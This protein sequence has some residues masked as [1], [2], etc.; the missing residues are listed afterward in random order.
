MRSVPLVRVERSGTVAVLTI[1]HPPVNTL[2]RPVRRAL[3][4]A[5]DSA[6]LDPGISAV[7]VAG[8]RDFSA[9]ADLAEL[10]SG[11]ALS[12]P[13]LH[14]D[15]AGL[16]DRMRVPSVAALSGVVLGGGLELALACSAR[17][18]APTA[19]FGLPET[20]IGLMPGG[21]GTQRLPRAIGIERGLN[22]IVSGRVIDAATAAAWGLV[23]DIVED[24]EQAALEHALRLA[25]SGERPRLRDVQ[26]T[27][28]LAAAFADIALR[29][30]R[31]AR[32][33]PGVLFAIEA[34]G[35][36]A[37]LP[38]DE[39]IALESSL[40][41]RLASTPEAKAARYRFLS[42]RASG[43]PAASVE[44]PARVAVVGAG[45]MGRGIAQAFLQAG[46]PA[47]LIDTDRGRVDAGVAAIRSS[48]DAAV[49]RKRL[50]ADQR[51]AQS[52]LLTTAV[53]LG[54]V[55]D[56]DLVIEAVFEN[57]AVKLDVFRELNR[58]AA[59]HTI[60]ASNTSSLDLDV[61]A[62]ATDRPGSVVGMHFFSP[63]N[64]MKL[65]EVV[66]G[67]KTTGRSLDTALAVTRKLGKT[68]VV[69]QVGPGFIGNR[70]FDQYLR[71]ANLLLH[72][73]VT[74]LQ[75]DSAL[76]SWGMAMGPFAVLDLIGNDV[77]WQARTERGDADP[78]WSIADAL[79]EAGSFG[80]KS[81]VGWYSYAE[82]KPVPNSALVLPDGPGVPADEVVL[83]CVL[84]MVNEAA[85]VLA[86]GIAASSRDIDTV[87][88]KGYG[89]P[90]ARGGPWF[91]AES[92]GFNHVL[93]AMRAWRGETGDAF[94]EPHAA[95]VEIGEYA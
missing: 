60:L 23:D 39:G 13:T 48:L 19:T 72:S 46:I 84:A 67:A 55:T 1:T 94:W 32:R 34:V 93:A 24:L 53:G 45:T 79:C 37:T 78:A 6:D 73:G 3:Y 65:V 58:V 90:A 80:R 76:Q 49:S 4:S 70:I 36:A 59:P 5:L 63:A 11:D 42:D 74:P 95:L 43:K 51:D 27:D 57:L 30:A 8:K 68:P 87:M 31:R 14:G 7:V 82:E 12:F 50:T 10:D 81:G 9:G 66:N 2:S 91:F 75:V 61:I 17:V 35:A 54:A 25:G 26:L 52:A 62:E 18:A 83:R 28:P 69:S 33:P 47:T 21:G 85:A 56:A 86:D 15:L 71:Q 64:V 16:L 22:L 29:D 40:F 38:F 77:A 88:T 89:F 44:L 41:A 20:T 92:L